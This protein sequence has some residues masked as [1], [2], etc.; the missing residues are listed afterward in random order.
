MTHTFFAAALSETRIHVVFSTVM[1]DGPNLVDPTKYTVADMGNNALTVLTVE[2]A[3]ALSPS[4][5]IL[6]LSSGLSTTNSYYVVVSGSV[7]ALDSTSI[8]PSTA[9]FQWVEGQNFC[10]VPNS[11]F[12]GEALGGLLGDHRGQVFFSPA[13]NTLA[14]NS[15]I[16]LESVEVCTTAYDTYTFPVLI[17][18]PPLFTYSKGGPTSVLGM[19]TVLWAPW[20]RLAEAQTNL[21]QT[22]YE[23]PFPQ[24]S[25]S[26]ATATFTE[27]WDHTYVSLLN[28]LGWKT[29]DNAG[30]PPVY[31][32]TANNT[33]PIPSGPT[34]TVVLEPFM[35]L[36]QDTLVVTDGV[37]VT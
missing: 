2:K 33:A 15:V 23:A 14:A 11:A 21:S 31:F 13:F 34:T 30:E 37:T 5:V 26:H 7:L 3:T 29:F 6:T 28:N 12:T 1:Q 19:A 8:V 18:P 4:S 10:L 16:Q 27:P 17:D 9:Y 20:P 24:A 32:K 35:L 36:G 25:D 22:L